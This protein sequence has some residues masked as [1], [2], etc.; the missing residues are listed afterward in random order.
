MT[1]AE[2]RLVLLDGELKTLIKDLGIKPILIAEG[3]PETIST[4]L[5]GK[6]SD[7]AVSVPASDFLRYFLATYLEWNLL[8]KRMLSIREEA[9][10][11]AGA[12]DRI[13]SN[14]RAYADKIARNK[15]AQT[16]LRES[17][18]EEF[19]AAVVERFDGDVSAFHSAPV[20]AV[21]HS[22]VELEQ[23]KRVSEH[24]AGSMPDFCRESRETFS[25]KVD[26]LRAAIRLLDPEMRVEL[27][28][29]FRARRSSML[30]HFHAI[31]DLQFTVI[32]ENINYS[33]Q[34]LISEILNDPS[35]RDSI[36]DAKAVIQTI[37]G[38]IANV[39]YDNLL[40]D[41]LD[42]LLADEI[43]PGSGDGGGG[44]CNIIPGHGSSHAACHPVLIALSKGDRGK[45][46][47]DAI[48]QRVRT[49][50]VKCRG[51]TRTVIFFSTT[52]DSAKFADTHFP[53]LQAIHSTDGVRFIFL[54][55]GT[56]PTTV[57]RAPVSF[58]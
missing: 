17:L 37:L 3:C 43:F 1:S 44:A 20:E 19:V 11:S 54:I 24:F 9:F 53:E 39:G 12:R 56:P 29:D 40:D 46:G 36:Y 47:F 25:D 5:F 22:V 15:Q 23:T 10:R 4:G 32:N 34:K 48:L 2:K 8:R 45:L 13:E 30:G 18:R 6:Q 57:T 38:A 33:M 58:L 49:H 41:I 21:Y 52:W 28:A 7:S 42:G 16:K 55:A 26:R 35:L 51:I 31:D 50:L 14:C 27:D